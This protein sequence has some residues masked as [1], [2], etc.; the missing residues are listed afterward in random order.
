MKNKKEKDAMNRDYDY[1][2]SNEESDEESLADYENT[3]DYIMLP[4]RSGDST[5]FD[6][7]DDFLNNFSYR[8]DDYDIEEEIEAEPINLDYTVSLTPVK[9]SSTEVVNV[10]IGSKAYIFLAN[11]N[12]LQ[13]GQKVVL[14][15]NDKN[16]NGVVVKENYERDLSSLSSKPKPLDVVE[17]INN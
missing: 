10:M 9:T 7:L 2:N 12:H 5:S 17:I 8:E 4:E 16:Y 15:I 14:R 1:G 3:D 13:N 6:S 11:G